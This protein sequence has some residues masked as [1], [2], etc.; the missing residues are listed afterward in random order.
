MIIAMG[1]G[2]PPDPE[3]IAGGESRIGVGDLLAYSRQGK[4][5]ASDYFE[6]AVL[7]SVT[8]VGCRRCG[9][10]LAGAPLFQMWWEGAAVAGEVARGPADIRGKWIRASP[11][12]S[13]Q[14]H[15]HSGRRSA[16]R[17][18]AGL[19]RHLQN[20]DFR[21]GGIDHVRGAVGQPAKG[22][23]YNRRHQRAEAGVRSNTHGAGGPGRMEISMAGGWHISPQP[24]AKWWSI[25]R[26]SSAIPTGAR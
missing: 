4:H 20:A 19:P 13:R 24:R 14:G 21:P 7:S 22:G 5:A 17:L 3:V 25:S 11:D 9:G 18:S 26:N 15:L 1:R 23:Q 16:L 6:D 2:G 12:S 10:G 8:T